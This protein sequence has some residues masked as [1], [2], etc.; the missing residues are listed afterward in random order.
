MNEDLYKA[1]KS[2]S[3][4]TEADQLKSHQR[5]FLNESI[6]EF[7]RNGFALSKSDRDY[8][9]VIKDQLAALSDQFS[10][11]I[12]AEDDFL[13]VNADDMEGLP[14]DYKEA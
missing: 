11:N 2:Y 12:A 9:K 7:E 14:V 4:L 1:I 10:E 3:K 5:K 6:I 8:L 13:E